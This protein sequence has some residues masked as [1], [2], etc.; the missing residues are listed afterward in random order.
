MDWEW[1]SFPP[2]G[3]GMPDWQPARVIG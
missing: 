1:E 2:I 3:S